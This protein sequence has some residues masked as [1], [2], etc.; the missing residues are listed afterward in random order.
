[1]SDDSCADF[2]IPYSGGGT[3]E[4]AAVSM[5][6]VAG[7][8]RRRVYAYIASKGPYGATDEEIELGLSLPSNTSR[9]RRWELYREG[10][11]RRSGITRK[12]LSN[13]NADVWVV[14]YEDQGGEHAEATGVRDSAAGPVVQDQRTEVA[15]GGE[16]GRSGN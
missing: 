4:E 1:M 10:K 11:I 9:P 14:K 16:C 12:T 6:E 8:L 5:R 3:S 13:R 15:A 2:F 7:V